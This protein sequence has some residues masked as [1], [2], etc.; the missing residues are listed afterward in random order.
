MAFEETW[1]DPVAHLRGAFADACL[2]EGR[3]NP[4]AVPARAGRRFI[5]RSS[6]R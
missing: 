4:L 3:R 6:P 5:G 1:L 2:P